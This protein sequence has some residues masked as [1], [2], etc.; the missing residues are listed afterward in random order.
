MTAVLLSLSILGVFA[1]P[2]L[3]DLPD[4][5][6]KVATQVVVNADRTDIRYDVGFNPKTL[7]QLLK[8]MAPDMSP[9]ATPTQ[10]TDALRSALK[11]KI[12]DTL[13][14]KVDGHD[15]EAEE[16]TFDQDEVSKHVQIRLYLKYEVLVKQETKLEITDGGFSNVGR[17]WNSG[18]KATLPVAIKECST[19]AIPQR[20]KA[21]EKAAGESE[22]FVISGTVVKLRIDTETKSSVS[23]AP[24]FV[25]FFALG[26][27]G[28][29]GLLLVPNESGADAHDDHH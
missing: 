29:V 18:F 27:A 24:L 1:D 21:T 22:P 9:D 17:I 5:V 4:G 7:D 19:K 26:G 12:A 28:M 8:D 25:L 13:K 6:V 3:H 15:V 23:M 2:T 11:E 10:K 14:V 20:T 16:V